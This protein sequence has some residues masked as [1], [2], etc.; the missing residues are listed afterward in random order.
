MPA[1]RFWLQGGSLRLITIYKYIYIILNFHLHDERQARDEGGPIACVREGDSINIDVERSVYIQ[2]P[3]NEL[4]AKAKSAVTRGPPQCFW[5][6]RVG[7]VVFDNCSTAV[8]FFSLSVKWESIS[9]CPLRPRDGL[10]LAVQKL[11]AYMSLE[12]HFAIWTKSIACIAANWATSFQ[13]SQSV[14]TVACARATL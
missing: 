8:S 6:A 9:E 1:W 14:Q 3:E 10:P 4:Q 13:R 12:T 11:S 5:A 7:A 2:L